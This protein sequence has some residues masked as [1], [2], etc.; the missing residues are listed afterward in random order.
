MAISRNESPFR[1]Q[2]I[3]TGTPIHLH[4]ASVYWNDYRHDWIMIG[5]QEY[6]DSL[7]GE[8]W[9]AEAPTPEGPWANAIKV[10]THHSSSDNYTFYNPTQ[11]PFFDEDGGRIIYFEGTYSNTFSGNS[12]PTPLYD[13][14]QMMYRLDLSTI[15]SLLPPTLVGDYNGDGKVD[16]ADYT[17]WRDTFGSTTDLRANGDNNGASQGVIDQADYLAWVQ[18]FGAIQAAGS[19]ATVPEPASIALLMFAAGVLAAISLM[20]SL[21]ACAT[22]ILDL[23]FQRLFRSKSASGLPRS[24]S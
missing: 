8:V 23:R 24:V 1:L 17:V 19:A 10:A 2:D 15:P 5:N 4:R 12:Q 11:D 18:N 16:A 7:L 20:S 9:F 14:N 3:A 22:S 13:Y 6:G 21:S